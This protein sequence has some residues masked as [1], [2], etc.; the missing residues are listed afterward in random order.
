MSL[1]CSFLR[2]IPEE[3][4]STNHG[5]TTVYERDIFSKKVYGTITDEQDHPVIGACVKLWDKKDR[6]VGFVKSDHNG[7]FNFQK[8]P[9]GLYKYT[10]EAEDGACFHEAYVRV[11]KGFDFK[12]QVIL[13]YCLEC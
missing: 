7:D 1:G 9:Y 10:V 5:C 6:L 2:E 4:C 13:H 8:I 12:I 11:Q 3:S